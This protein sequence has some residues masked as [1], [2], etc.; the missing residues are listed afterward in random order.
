MKDKPI[1]SIITIVYNDKNNLEKTILS[2]V[3]QI[4]NS[5][6]YIVI[7]GGSSDGTVDIIK[8]NSKL[9]SFWLSEKDKGISD[10]F[11]KGVLH[12]NGEFILFLNA[13]DVMT[14][15]AILNMLLSVKSKTS[16]IYYGSAICRIKDKTGFRFKAIPAK[17]FN[18]IHPFLC[19]Q[20]IF[21]KAALFDEIG[22]FDTHLRFAMDYDW[23]LKCVL[24]NKILTI[25]DSDLVYYSLGGTSDQN[26]IKA[27]EE[28]RDVALKHGFDYNK[29]NSFY[30]KKIF[31]A[32]LQIIFN[33]IG[34]GWIPIKI[35]S[36]Y[37]KQYNFIK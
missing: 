2:V 21:C 31:K 34:I 3:N 28:C 8:Q 6:E 9:L 10:A 14:E 27:L 19:H 25:V 36:I 16:D 20:A 35:K 33:K 24:K 1:I 30:R 32:K 4:Q 7:D 29:T 22:L 11:N 37:K 15:N 26:I 5:I 12:A 23:Y 13:G 17:D 18:L